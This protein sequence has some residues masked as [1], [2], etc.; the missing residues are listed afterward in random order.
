MLPRFFSLLSCIKLERQYE[1]IKYITEGGTNCNWFIVIFP[2]H[3]D[4]LG[5]VSLTSSICDQSH[6][7][8]MR[9]N[10]SFYC[11][12]Q[13]L[14]RFGHVDDTSKRVPLGIIAG[15]KGI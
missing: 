12:H 15:K 11:S 10:T 6:L 5:N 13:S 8:P 4:N 2:R 14:S 1:N 3:E 7:Q 9:I